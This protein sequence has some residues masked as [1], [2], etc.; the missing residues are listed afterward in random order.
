MHGLAVAVRRAPAIVLL[1]WAVLGQEVEHSQELARGG[2]AIAVA[3]ERECAREVIEG[4]ALRVAEL[5]AGR[6]ELVDR[7]R[8]FAAANH[9]A[10]ELTRLELAARRLERRLRDDQLGAIRLVSAL[11]AR[12]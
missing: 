8:R 12:R 1:R 2:R 7:D 11:E 4:G 9:N 3:V 10:V 6:D 5:A